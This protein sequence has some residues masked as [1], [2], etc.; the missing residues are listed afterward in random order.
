[1]TTNPLAASAAQRADEPAPSSA[2]RPVLYG[3]VDL[4][5]APLDDEPETPEE[6]AAVAE[7]RAELARG[8][9]TMTTDELLRSLG[10]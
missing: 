5:D 10:L 6:A 7:A 4:A 9:K 2:A 8:G 1:M 3:P